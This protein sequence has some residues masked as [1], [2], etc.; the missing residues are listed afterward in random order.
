M[1]KICWRE[2][3]VNCT[4]IAEIEERLKTAGSPFLQWNRKAERGV[5]GDVD[6]VGIPIVF[7]HQRPPIGLTPWFPLLISAIRTVWEKVDGDRETADWNAFP[8]RS[9]LW[10]SRPS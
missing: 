10:H 5:Y 7:S 9:D 3:M 2:N 1:G 8:C 4:V 6:L